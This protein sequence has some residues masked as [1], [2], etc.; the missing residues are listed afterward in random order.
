MKS[1]FNFIILILFLIL[2]PLRFGETGYF[3]V[4]FSITVFLMVLIVVWFKFLI[5]ALFKSI[6]GMYGLIPAR[7]I[8]K[9]K[10]KRK[11]HSLNYCCIYVWDYIRLFCGNKNFRTP[12]TTGSKCECVEW[13]CEGKSDNILLKERN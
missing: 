2:F 13:E 6:F 5:T 1:V 9:K 8:M 4:L 3:I 10:K 12:W 7:D 11:K